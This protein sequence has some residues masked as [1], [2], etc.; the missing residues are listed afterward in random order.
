MAK[1]STG[2]EMS[3]ASNPSFS[4]ITQP[5]S[6]LPI[7]FVVIGSEASAERLD[8][9][10]AEQAPLHVR[11]W[12]EGVGGLPKAHKEEDSSPGWTQLSRRSSQ[13]GRSDSTENS[14]SAENRLKIRH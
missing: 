5:F 9:P 14:A 7:P 12:N 1:L 4:R 11:T 8:R 6:L 3:V 13:E 2:S 10:F